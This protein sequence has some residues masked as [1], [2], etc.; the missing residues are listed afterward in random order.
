MPENKKPHYMQNE[1]RITTDQK[2]CKTDHSEMTY[3]CAKRKKYQP[4]T[5]S[6]ENILQKGRWMK[7]ISKQVKAEKIVASKTTL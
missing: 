1:I 7:A 6:S 4:I 2:W 5:I 3:L